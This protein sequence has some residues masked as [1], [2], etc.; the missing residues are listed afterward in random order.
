MK[1]NDFGEKIGGAKKD[2]WKERNFYIDDLD[3]LSDGEAFKYCTKEQVWKKP[4]YKKLCEY[5]SKLL[6]FCIKK[7]RDSLP[8]K[9]KATSDT[10]KNLLNRKKFVEFIS[11]VR[12]IAMELKSEEELKDLFQRIF[13]A[14]GYYSNKGWT[15]KVYRNSNITNKFVK[16]VQAIPLKLKHFQKEINR[17]GFPDSFSN[18]KKL[19]VRELEP[20]KFF[21]C[22][23]AASGYCYS[24]ICE[25]PFTS[26]EEAQEYIK[27]ISQSKSVC[28]FHLK[29][30]ELENI[31]RKGKYQRNFQVSTSDIYKTFKFRGGEFG[32]Y[33]SDSERQMHL[34][35]CFDALMDLAYI[36]NVEP[37]F[38]ALK[39]KDGSSLGIAFGSRGS[40]K[41][42]AHYEPCRNVI[43]I[44]KVKGAGSLAHEWG[45][46]MD[47]FFGN[48]LGSNME[49]PFASSSIIFKNNTVPNEL[50][51]S[52]N[53][54]V[55]SIKFTYASEEKAKEQ[56]TKENKEIIEI[57]EKKKKS[58]ESI[59]EHVMETFSCQQEQYHGKRILR[60]ASKDEIKE[61]N[62]FLDDILENN[63]SAEPVYSLYKKVKG[64]IPR[65]AYRKNIDL[66]IYQISILKKELK[67]IDEANVLRRKESSNFLKESE[68]LDNARKKPYYSSI[69]EMLA[70]AFEAYVEDAMTQEQFVSQ[71]LVHSTSNSV[72]FSDIKPY[73]ESQERK[74]INKNF[75]NFFVLL[76][77][78]LNVK[79]FGTDTLV[80]SVGIEKSYENKKVIESYGVQGIFVGKQLSLF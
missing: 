17:I 49:H 7:I 16:N 38:L 1:I 22:R 3:T 80:Q 68:K 21:V 32:N 66:I 77:K 50:V 51:D 9:V 70:R 34:N 71:Y 4:D 6:V 65:K 64:R 56:T 10:E 76:K 61:F 55:D 12:D 48:M 45:H 44:T 28:A 19:E 78:Y 39:R 54:L 29:K 26:D 46:S 31:K 52:F 59:M 41:A 43:N 69:V 5:K 74:N 25:T 75:E 23:S 35:Y 60:A 79:S 24:R 58:L 33:A 11:L 67:N 30:P 42:V 13:I 62:S 14:N 15:V 36:L 47:A 8:A 53:V 72:Y 73:P 40:G 18:R 57:I 63:S 20:G 27:T 2:L 37:S